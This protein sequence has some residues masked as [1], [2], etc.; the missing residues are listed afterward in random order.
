MF[1]LVT[2]FSFILSSYIVVN[3]TYVSNFFLNIFLQQI[4]DTLRERKK[5]N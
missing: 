4:F 1:A 3:L 2:V 5:M